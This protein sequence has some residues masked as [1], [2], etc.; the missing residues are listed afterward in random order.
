M[1]TVNKKNPLSAGVAIALAMAVWLT[2]TATAAEEPMRSMKGG[3]HMLML[4]GLNTTAEAD[5]LKPE[6]T[7][8]MV[9]AKCKTVW[10][11]RVKQGLKG[12]QLLMANGKTT[13]LIGTHGCK[14]CKSII[15]VT[16]KAKADITELKHSCGACGDDSAFCCATK[17]G[18]DATK[19]MGKKETEKK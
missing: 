3:E 19:G 8:A 5:A 10:T 17:S 14:G 13:E 2:T 18:A 11:T 15:T 6:D 1:K 12:A 7:I 16:G 4:Q 9:C